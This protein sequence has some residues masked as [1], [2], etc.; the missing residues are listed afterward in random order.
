[1]QGA[2]GYC[3]EV[4]REESLAVAEETFRAA[5]CRTLRAP[6]LVFRADAVAEAVCPLVGA[7]GETLTRWTE[8]VSE[9][10]P[11]TLLPFGIPEAVALCAGTGQV[12]CR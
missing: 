7:P 5:G 8:I 12:S 9:Y 3:A 6:R 11:R 1:M 4:L 10:V 2:R